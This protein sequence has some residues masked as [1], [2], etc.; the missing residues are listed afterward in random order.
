MGHS[1]L[2]VSQRSIHPTPGALERVVDRLQAI[3]ARASDSF[4]K[5]QKQQLATAVSATLRE[6]TLVSE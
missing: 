6:L 4:P 5:R 1:S 2:T 3:S